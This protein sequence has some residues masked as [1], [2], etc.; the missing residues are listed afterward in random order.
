MKYP[1]PV[2]LTVGDAEPDAD[3]PQIGHLD[4]VPLG[5]LGGSVSAE[6]QDGHVVAGGAGGERQAV[7]IRS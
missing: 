3:E 1:L 6:E 2:G 5:L 7:Q 4:C